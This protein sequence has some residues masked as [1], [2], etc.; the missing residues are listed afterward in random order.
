MMT[1]RTTN[2]LLGTIAM[3][4]WAN[5]VISTFQVPIASAQGNNS[6]LQSIQF[7]LSGIYNGTCVNRKICG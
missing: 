3:A 6:A 5:L 2:I 7:S 1:S 4:L